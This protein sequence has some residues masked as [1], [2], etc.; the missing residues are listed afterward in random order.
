MIWSDKA[1][2]KLIL[3]RQLNLELKKLSSVDMY[4]RN[5]YIIEFDDVRERFW[6]FA[7][8]IESND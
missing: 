5:V 6:N 4:F 3:K 1:S 7:Y 2:W 8:A